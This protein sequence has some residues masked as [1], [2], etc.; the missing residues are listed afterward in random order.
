MEILMFEILKCYF[1]RWW[2]GGAYAS[3]NVHA[4]FSFHPIIFPGLN[5]GRNQNEA[6][7]NMRV[8]FPRE[9]HGLTTLGGMNI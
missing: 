6:G 5:N 3:C 8:M 4:S 7:K 2:F 9:I 1:P